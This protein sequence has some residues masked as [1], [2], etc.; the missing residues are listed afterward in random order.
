MSSLSS[1]VINEQFSRLARTTQAKPG[2]QIFKD[3]GYKYIRLRRGNIPP[4]L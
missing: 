1:A 2:L 4:L 3:H